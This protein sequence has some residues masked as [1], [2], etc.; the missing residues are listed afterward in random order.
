M[1]IS[2][3]T[4]ETGAIKKGPD[5]ITLTDRPYAKTKNVCINYRTSGSE[6]LLAYTSVGTYTF[7]VPDGVT[8]INYIMVGGGGGGGKSL[9]DYN[10]SG[11]IRPLTGG[12]FTRN[13]NALYAG[14]G[15][16][17]GQLVQG[18][19]SAIGGAVLTIQVGKGG[20]QN[21]AS[22]NCGREGP[23]GVTRYGPTRS[24][25]NSLG[26]SGQPSI[27]K[28]RCSTVYNQIDIDN[29]KAEGERIIRARGG[30][31]GK[32]ANLGYYYQPYGSSISYWK[33]SGGCGGHS[34]FPKY[35]VDTRY[36]TF[37]KVS[38]ELCD[39]VNGSDIRSY[40]CGYVPYNCPFY[41][42]CPVK[43]NYR[44]WG[45]SRNGWGNIIS[46]KCYPRIPETV[47]DREAWECGPLADISGTAYTQYYYP[48]VDSRWKGIKYNPWEN[49]GALGSK[50][51][52]L[53]DIEYRW[54]E[55]KCGGGGAGTFG[56]GGN[57]S[58]GL[59]CIYSNSLA[60]LKYGQGRWNRNCVRPTAAQNNIF[61]AA[62]PYSSQCI[63]GYCY[64]YYGRQGYY[65]PQTVNQAMPGSG[66]PLFASSTGVNGIGSKDL[67]WDITV[68]NCAVWPQGYTVGTVGSIVNIQG[69][70]QGGAGGSSK[71]T[72]L[73]TEIKVKCC[74]GGLPIYVTPAGAG[75]NSNSPGNAGAVYISYQKRYNTSVYR[76][77]I[78]AYQHLNCQELTGLT[79][80]P[81]P[82]YTPPAEFPGINLS[83]LS[84]KI[85][86][87]NFLTTTTTKVFDN[88]YY[89][90][91][92]GPIPGTGL[93]DGSC[94][95]PTYTRTV[96]EIVPQ[97][98]NS[99]LSMNSFYGKCFFKIPAVNQT[100]K[101][102]PLPYKVT[103]LLPP[104]KSRKVSLTITAWGGGGGGS[105]VVDFPI[106]NA[107][108]ATQGFGGG[109]GAGGGRIQSSTFGDF[110]IGK[111]FTC[112]RVSIGSGGSS[113]AGGIITNYS[114][115]P[116][117]KG[118]YTLSG[119]DGTGGDGGA[120]YITCW[121]GTPY[122]PNA[123]N[124][125]ERYGKYDY[126]R[127]QGGKGGFGMAAYV[128]GKSTGAHGG[129]STYPGGLQRY[130][131]DGV[132]KC[133]GGGGGGGAGGAGQ[134]G[135][136]DEGA[137][138]GGRGG[139][140][141]RTRIPSACAYGYYGLQSAPTQLVYVGGGGG[142]GGTVFIDSYRNNN[143]GGNRALGNG[144]LCASTYGGCG[145]TLLANLT[146]VTAIDGRSNLGQGG[147]GAGSFVALE[148]YFVPNVV[149]PG[150]KKNA[151]YTTPGA[152]VGA[153]GAASVGGTTSGA[154]FAIAAAIGY[155]FAA[156]AS[157]NVTGGQ[158]DTRWRRST[159]VA[160]ISGG[161]G[162]SGGLLIS[163]P[164]CVT[165]VLCDSDKRYYTYNLSGGCVS[166]VS[167]GVAYH[168]F[169]YSSTI[170][171][172]VLL[173]K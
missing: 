55:H 105:G 100:C 75:G 18:H 81:G 27:I 47:L 97:A 87:K 168:Y 2:T 96:T 109:G 157:I 82:L 30:H 37:Y 139:Y 103:D 101:P 169:R 153:I 8:R 83:S 58:S 115:S 79:E 67:R 151:G 26:Q 5:Q 23:C 129:S 53:A 113:Y 22:N 140:G 159:T 56:F 147:G 126:V 71:R 133:G 17:G 102:P 122:G 10:Y 165:G 92:L 160:T 39:P 148:V 119:R 130:N 73:D 60:V 21:F 112:L 31:G 135:L 117:P 24:G 110:S 33:S 78:E 12:N 94:N 41:K 158:L 28:V 111:C 49:S 15:G 32:N 152:V 43:E 131:S 149:V 16:G 70:G 98:G 52:A 89:R 4:I 138:C 11:D 61:L 91:D 35:R 29:F 1:M 3:S 85:L 88:P 86:A 128:T 69:W 132:N 72:D 40:N 38:P 125:L 156:S 143:R 95:L 136:E 142:G 68:S 127:A 63:K 162:G 45:M 163:Y 99:P 116:A 54:T 118:T 150:S 170:R 84:T 20:F 64:P 50:Y 144:G 154:G 62:D 172:Y 65:D 141:V 173:K 36:S 76:E 124:T 123:T 166:Y 106:N 104:A 134:N 7:T 80:V 25:V 77:I 14:G 167:N 13:C 171:D 155:K 107:V 74:S 59:T 90:E 114:P 34:W 137:V 44:P 93:G 42:F 108:A 66:V 164:W 161:Y 48:G 121:S 51:N 146:A 145:G 57:Y 19:F 6:V 46:D 9:N 120:T